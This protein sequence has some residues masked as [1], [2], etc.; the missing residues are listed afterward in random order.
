M[1]N[2]YYSIQSQVSEKRNLKK[3]ANQAL[4]V[5]ILLLFISFSTT[6]KAQVNYTD[7]IPDSHVPI[8]DTL[9]IDLNHD[10]TNDF[11]IFMASDGYSSQAFYIFLSDQTYVAINNDSAS[12][13]EYGETINN[14]LEWSNT[15][16]VRML[17]FD[18]ASSVGNWAGINNGYLGIKLSIGNETYYC[19]LR[20]HIIGDG[21]PTYMY[22]LD[23]AINSLANEEIHAGDG[24]PA[25]ATSLYTQDINDYFDGRDIQITFTKAFNENLFTEYRIFL[26]KTD[27]ENAE[28]LDYMN[29]LAEDKYLSIVTDPNNQDFK[30]DTILS[31]ESTDIDGDA[32]TPNTPYKIHILNIAATGNSSDNILSNPSNELILES[33]TGE[34]KNIMVQDIDNNNSSKDVQVSFTAAD[35]EQFV[36]EY[37]IF[38]SPIEESS[39]FTAETA[40]TLSDEFYTSVDPNANTV[41]ILNDHQKDINGQLIEEGHFYHAIIL[42]ITNV[43]PISGILSNPSRMFIL[44]NPNYFSAGQ[45]SGESIEYHLA[46]DVLSN[47]D[48]W[49]GIKG[50]PNYDWGESEIDI[51][52]DGLVDFHLYGG[53]MQHL[54]FDEDYYYLVPERDNKVLHCEHTEHT[55]I[56]ILQ[57]GDA[58]G[59]GYNFT[60]ESCLL[61][62]VVTSPDFPTQHSGHLPIDFSSTNYYI[63][64]CIMDG[65]RPQYGWLRLGGLRFQEYAFIDINSGTHQLD[66]QNNFSVF[67]NPASDF[68]HIQLSDASSL[69]KNNTVSIINSLGILIDEFSLTNRSVSKN[70]STYPTGLYFFV[71]KNADGILER[72]K[73]IVN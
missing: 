31:Q 62:K 51:N 37:R 59:D 48:T 47:T 13:I 42:S 24:L 2:A 49:N 40:L 3:I 52:R 53:F 28:D 18:D 19:W 38:I 58:I 22:A 35:D 45:R 27:D 64:F 11:K 67:P 68:I 5:F 15:E 6:S 44:K 60:N 39:N 23:Y 65:N 50:D 7:I 56:D 21:W 25:G 8:N 33:L 10:G 70:I 16:R 69:L 20:L 34:A 43:Y 17:Y 71:I 46:D 26:A 32:I 30:I 1:K 72:H 73:V 36:N 9:I 55:W 57:E 61:N 12:V 29:Q 54:S 4:A 41:I 66:T 63:G 14:E